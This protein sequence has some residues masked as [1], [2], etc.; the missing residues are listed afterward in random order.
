MVLGSFRKPRTGAEYSVAFNAKILEVQNSFCSSFKQ[1]RF[2]PSVQ[3][4]NK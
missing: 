2:V 1:C 3:K 4:Q